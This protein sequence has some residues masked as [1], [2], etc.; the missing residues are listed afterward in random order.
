MIRL[1]TFNESLRFLFLVVISIG[2]LGLAFQQ[3]YR[4]ILT[5]A[6]RALK[7][8]MQLADAIPVIVAI[9]DEFKPNSGGSLRDSMDRIEDSQRKLAEGHREIVRRV[10]AIEGS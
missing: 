7:A 1:D 4:H 6:W 8:L 3:I 9:A 10:D 5:P 2:A